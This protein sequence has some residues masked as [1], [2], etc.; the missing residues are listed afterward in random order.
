MRG[1]ARRTPAL[2]FRQHPSRDDNEPHLLDAIAGVT[3]ELHMLHRPSFLSGFDFDLDQKTYLHLGHLGG[4]ENEDFGG[5]DGAEAEPKRR[6]AGALGAG[7][8]GG[9]D[10]G[11]ASKEMRRGLS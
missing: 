4:P 7:R 8:G 11:D 10:G 2:P 1:E 6:E 3:A 9:G 5:L